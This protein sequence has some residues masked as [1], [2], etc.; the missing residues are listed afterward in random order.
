MSTEELKEA[1]KTSIEGIE[2]L[3]FLEAL[4]SIIEKRQQNSQN[5]YTTE[6]ID[7]HV[8]QIMKDNHELLKRLAQ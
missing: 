7:L 3:N 1:I 2:D 8:E 4:K 5:A 6:N